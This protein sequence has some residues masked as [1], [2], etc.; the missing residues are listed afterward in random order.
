[1]V[2]NLV[3]TSRQWNKAAQ[4]FQDRGHRR[5]WNP[6]EKSKIETFKLDK[7]YELMDAVDVRKMYVC[8][9]CIRRIT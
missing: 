9:T 7:I 5:S 2:G 6:P 8:N 3:I 4:V 1:M